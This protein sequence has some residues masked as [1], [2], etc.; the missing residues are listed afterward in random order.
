MLTDEVRHQV[1]KRDGNKCQVCGIQVSRFPGLLPQTH[2]RV[3]E[4]VG[5]T[6]S[7]DNLITLCF[8]CH[9][10]MDSSGHRKLFVDMANDQYLQ[11]IPWLLRDV[12]IELLAYSERLDSR[13]LP[14]DQLVQILAQVENLFDGLRAR[15]VELPETAGRL[16][17][18]PSWES[19]VP[20]LEIAWQSH[21]RER[22]LNRLLQR[23]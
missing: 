18:P 3:P 13:S 2:H 12:G 4:S 11:F 17:D 1:W 6:D 5:G 9:A 20:G 23:D 7:I 22:H 16:S 10:L 14:R 19:I 21:T 8:P 15:L